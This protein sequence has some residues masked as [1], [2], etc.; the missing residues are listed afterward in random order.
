M[1]AERA[2]RARSGGSQPAR[3]RRCKKCRKVFPA[4]K[5]M[6]E[7]LAGRVRVLKVDT[8]KSEELAMDLG[9]SKLPHFKLFKNGAPVADFVGSDPAKLRRAIDAQL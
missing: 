6:S 5:D 2:A 7:E 9:V 4:V 3:P 1:R 8:V